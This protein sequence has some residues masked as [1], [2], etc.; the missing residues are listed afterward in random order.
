MLVKSR[1]F[2]GGA[3]FLWVSW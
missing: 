3:A 2:S 1:T